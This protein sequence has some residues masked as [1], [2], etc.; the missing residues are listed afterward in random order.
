MSIFQTYL[1]GLAVAHLA[2]FYF[3][4]CGQLLRSRVP[5]E[6]D[7]FSLAD[8]IITSV[9][10]MALSGFGLLFLGF[11]RL[12]NHFG[13]FIAFILE[14]VLFWL[15]RGDN[16]LSWTFWRT[17]LE[18]FIKAWTVPAFFI[19]LLFLV[20]GLPAVLPP[21]F[22]DSI[23]Y[24]L[25]YAVD[26]PNAGRIYVDPFLR[27]PY[28]A[29]NFL[30]FYSALFVLKLGY[31]CHFL[32]WLCGLL[33]CLGILAFFTP[34]ETQPLG[35]TSGWR[36]LEP[37]QF[38]I[39]LCV[40]L[41]P[42]FLRYL[43]VGYVDVPIGLFVLI[44]I[45]CAYRSS[46]HRAFE[47]EL[48]VTGAFC[49][50]MKLTLIGHLPFFLGSLLFASARRL[51]AREIALLSLILLGLSLPWYVRN[52]IEVHDPVPP[53]L[54]SYFKYPDAIYSSADA[55]IYTGDTF[56]ERE[57]LHLVL[58][59]FRFF[60]DPESRNFREWGVSA[61]VLLVYAPILFLIAQLCLRGIWRPPGG[62]VY[63]SVAVAYL[64]LP[65]L[66]SS[67]GRYSLHWYPTFAAWLGVIISHIRARAQAAWNSRLAIWITHV[68]TV[69]FC[70]ALI[71]P[72]PTE[73]CRR[74]YRSYYTGTL[75]LFGSST[76]LRAYLKKN[77]TGYLASQAVIETL[78][79][80]QK[81]SSRV[82][83][84]YTE[85]LA[86]YFR[87]AK[88]ISVGDY[89]GP[90]RYS[91]LFKAVERGD[92]LPYLTRLD[93]SAV[94]V[95]PSTASWW[96]SLYE[97]FRTQLKEDGFIEYR[98]GEEQIPI[99]LRSDIKPTRKLKHMMP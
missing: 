98:S 99:F 76:E 30:L 12:L 97:K 66:L 14:G 87:K 40:A 19:Y 79:F 20:L 2:W 78:A 42:V 39:P 77:L 93:I 18:R 37:Q 28:Y 25:A 6:S 57:P 84:L 22:A 70:G 52:F 56:T 34:P 65:W 89:F 73:G 75:P 31:Y 50:G 51:R 68:A 63:L 71:Y 94:I 23:S 10:G 88:I 53:I 54:S 43:N 8:L 69:A 5:D 24:H 67:L 55:R 90:A 15:L 74:F 80:N 58:L 91:D 45:L 35:Q 85:P 95:T 13:I 83:A 17:M 81:K 46:A 26:W 16:W 41:S 72:T 62:V 86:F 47:R 9:T 7:S 32:T 48:V 49:A 59:P 11:A 82:L 60:T 29:N 64:T 21:I 3:F 33:T 27:F 92:C 61:M 44:P 38:L 96:P 4:T 36:K 1:M